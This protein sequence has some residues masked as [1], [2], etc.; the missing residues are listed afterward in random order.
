MSYNQCVTLIRLFSRGFFNYPRALLRSVNYY[1]TFPRAGI[2]Q[3]ENK[4]GAVSAFGITFTRA[5]ASGL[6]IREGLAGGARA[7]EVP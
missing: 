6:P 3:A 4:R 1:S 5:P 2:R 7:G